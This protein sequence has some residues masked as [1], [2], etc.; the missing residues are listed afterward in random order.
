M[1]IRAQLAKNPIGDLWAP[2]L[3]RLCPTF[4][5]EFDSCLPAR[6]GQDRHH[7]QQLRQSSGPGEPDRHQ[8]LQEDGHRHYVPGVDRRTQTRICPSLGQR[9]AHN[10]LLG[11]PPVPNDPPF[12]QEVHMNPACSF[13]AH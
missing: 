8:L 3:S 10:D 4:W 5:G 6:S 7:V 12:N 1:K 13:D 9:F 2:T 11:P